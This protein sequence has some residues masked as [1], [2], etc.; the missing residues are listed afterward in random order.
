MCNQTNS[1]ESNYFFFVDIDLTSLIG[2]LSSANS[3]D[4]NTYLYS[5]INVHSNAVSGLEKEKK[6]VDSGKKIAT[7]LD[8]D[9]KDLAKK[10]SEKSS[11][12]DDN[13][14]NKKRDSN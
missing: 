14:D 9:D 6:F 5:P 13:S 11:G 1:I 10:E 4:T 3:H 12:I 2:D 8:L 7:T